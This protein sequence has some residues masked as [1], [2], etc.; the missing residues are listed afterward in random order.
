MEIN[1]WSFQL[2]VAL[3]LA[4]TKMECNKVFFMMIDDANCHEYQPKTLALDCMER[5]WMKKTKKQRM[6]Y[7]KI[8]AENTRKTY[9]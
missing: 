9:C 8:I 4:L 1:S 7:N 2:S 3:K 6:L 5:T